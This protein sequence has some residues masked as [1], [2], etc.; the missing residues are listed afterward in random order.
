M[1]GMASRI[2]WQPTEVDIKDWQA[3]CARPHIEK[4]AMVTKTQPNHTNPNS[5]TRTLSSGVGRLFSFCDKTT[6]AMRIR[7][8]DCGFGLA[9]AARRVSLQP[10]ISIWL[11][12]KLGIK[13]QRQWFRRS[14]SVE[15]LGFSAYLFRIVVLSSFWSQ[16][17]WHRRRPVCP[18]RSEVLWHLVFWY[19]GS[20]LP[21]VCMVFGM[22][23]YMYV[24][25]AFA[26]CQ[27]VT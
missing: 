21:L 22:V 13:T 25:V 24:Y 20:V 8:V 9:D 11:Q 26:G 16:H 12:P 19:F 2:W 1:R 5:E 18:W 10:G 3:L 4:I 14:F 7:E 17:C 6:L 23:V 27:R 15:S